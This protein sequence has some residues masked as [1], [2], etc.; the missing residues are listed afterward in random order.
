MYIVCNLE[1]VYWNLSF[2]GVY[3]ERLV[4]SEVEGSRSAQDDSNPFDY[5]QGSTLSE[6]EGS[7]DGER[8]R[9][10]CIFFLGYLNIIY[11]EVHRSE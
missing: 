6:I 4:L 1:F 10:I 3:T 7:K 9:T 11:E 2:D 8:N 5:A